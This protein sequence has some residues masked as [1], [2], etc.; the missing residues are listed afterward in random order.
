M[1]PAAEA[2]ASIAA[3]AAV[4]YRTLVGALGEQGAAGLE[5]QGWPAR[6][7][8]VELEPTQV[9]GIAAP[10]LV[11]LPAVRRT[12]AA[13][14]ATPGAGASAVHAADEFEGLVERL[15]AAA[16]RELLIAR[17]GT[18][19]AAASRQ[20]RTLEQRV[21]PHL[22]GELARVER[23]L[24]EREREERVRIRHLLRRG[25]QGSEP[26]RVAHRGPASSSIQPGA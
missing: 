24:D 23:A 12:L 25:R 15:L 26:L 10:R 2:R 20:V 4:A 3:Q 7:L 18:A 5:P 6:T 17:L 13:R 1:R 11:S 9:W 14:A 21:A 19:L 22:R 16:S 8:E